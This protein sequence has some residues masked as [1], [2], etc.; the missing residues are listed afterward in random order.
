PAGASDAPAPAEWHNDDILS[1]EANPAAR[2][3]RLRS[4]AAGV[5]VQFIRVAKVGMQPHQ[6]FSCEELESR[7]WKEASHRS[8]STQRRTALVFMALSVGLSMIVAHHH[9]NAASHYGT[10]TTS[11]GGLNN[12]R[13]YNGAVEEVDA[14][15]LGVDI[16][17][18]FSYGSNT[19]WPSVSIWSTGSPVLWI[20]LGGVQGTPDGLISLL[21]GVSDSLGTAGSHSSSEG[22][23][24]GESSAGSSASA[25]PGSSAAASAAGSSSASSSAGSSAGSSASSAAGAGSSSS[26]SA[27][28]S[29]ASISG[30]SSALL[31]QLP[32]N[33]LL[34]I[35]VGTTWVSPWLL[36]PLGVLE[37]LASW[38]CCYSLTIL[39]SSH[40]SWTALNLAQ[41]YQALLLTALV[42]LCSSTWWPS[43]WEVL[44]QRRFNSRAL[45]YPL[46]RSIYVLALVT[47]AA[48]ST[49]SSSPPDFVSQSVDEKVLWRP[50]HD[51]CM[52]IVMIMLTGLATSCLTLLESLVYPP[53]IQI[54][55][56]TRLSLLFMKALT[57]ALVLRQLY[58]YWSSTQAPACITSVGGSSNVGSGAAGGGRL[59]QHHQGCTIG[60]LEVPA[61][62]CIEVLLVIPVLVILLC[63]VMWTSFLR[64]EGH[65]RRIFIAKVEEPGLYMTR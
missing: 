43:G 20:E 38:P 17:P 18:A 5:A 3:F 23:L 53:M 42:S 36:L 58:Y 12:D 49:A 15:Q 29:A 40:A 6:P 32:V 1:A 16:N 19:C 7:F 4:A 9:H 63:F 30:S 31:L 14:E 25:S 57:Q 13:Y 51:D 56:S 45:V 24:A 54:R 59:Y 8:W 62:S 60:Q 10:M 47:S 41:Y 65:Q 34:W 33:S 48:G 11:S 26:A 39:S 46:I 21:I 44:S 50:N 55:T 64:A 52:I 61:T 22:K 37:V 28:A 2:S 27:S 35:L